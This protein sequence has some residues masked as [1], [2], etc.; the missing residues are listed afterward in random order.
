MKLR[1]LAAMIAVGALASAAW[2][3]C[4]PEK[5]AKDQKATETKV[6]LTGAKSG[7]CDKANK[8]ETAS[9]DSPC[10]HAKEAQTA[11]QKPGC[12]DKAKQAETASAKPGCCDKAKGAQTASAKSGGCKKAA[13]VTTASQKP[14]CCDKAKQ[15]ET[16]SAKPGC[17]DKAKGVQT[18]STG[19]GCSKSGTAQT[20]STGSGC[21]KPCG[22][23]QTASTGSGCSKSASA[24]T[25]STGS[26][27]PTTAKVQA[28]LASLP[29]MT[30][31]VGDKSTCCDKAAGEMAK[32]SGSKIQY[33]IGEQTFDA[34]GDAVA[35]LAKM[36]DDEAA[37]MQTIQFAAG[38]N[39]YQC[40]MTAKSNAQDGKIAY[41]VGGVDFETKE[42]AEKAIENIKVALAKVEMGYK[43]GDKSYK[44]GT[45]AGKDADTAKAKLTY[46]VGDQETCCKIQAS[47][48]LA[49]A[50]VRTI[51]EAAVQTM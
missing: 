48:M 3:L 46:V 31:K 10:P 29:S 32:E 19:S 12:C 50:K 15:A 35:Q 14:G 49:Q 27:C 45:T 44:C 11:S 43:V 37:K 42:Q 7:G 25:A 9:T 6:E 47:M 5:C 40:P 13:T 22:T 36:I 33:V 23:T 8:A 17:C 21:N 38:G 1:N 24:Q 41:R 34:E 18:V 20:A 39:C 2:A 30:Y 28:V 16:A 4:P 26:G 51:V